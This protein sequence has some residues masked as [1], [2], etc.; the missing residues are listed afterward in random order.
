MDDIKVIHELN[1][2]VNQRIIIIKG[3][4]ETPL[5]IVT[6]ESKED[7]YYHAMYLK[8]YFDFEYLEDETLQQIK[9]RCYF[10]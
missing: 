5:D 8:N 3:D 2:E 7:S 10:Y 6:S 9:S 1:E 4:S